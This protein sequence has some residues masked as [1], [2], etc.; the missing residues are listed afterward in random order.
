MDELIL[1]GAGRNCLNLCYIF[2]Q[3]DTQIS[4]IIVD[5]NSDKWNRRVG[6]YL[7]ESPDRIREFQ[8]MTLCITI[9]DIKA[10]KQIRIELQ[11]K[12]Q[13]NLEKEI[14]FNKLIIQV[15]EKSIKIKESMLRQKVVYSTKKKI[16]FESFNG[17]GLGGIESWIKGICKALIKAGV[18]DLYILSGKGNYSI[19]KVLENHILYTDIHY[20]E[21]YS[22]ESIMG[23]IEIIMHKL[24]CK[25]IVSM[26]NDV[27]LAAY[28]IKCYYPE[29]I[30]IIPVIH[31]GAE[32][33][34]DYY[35]DYNK[36]YGFYIVVSQDIRN[37]MVK[38]GIEPEKIFSITCP[39]ECNKILSRTY[40]DIALK[41]IQI[42][43]AG[44]MDGM[45][46]SQKRMDLLLK[47]VEVLIKKD[48]NFNMEFAGD[49]PARCRME[50]IVNINHWDNRVHFI[51]ILQNSKISDFWKEKDI[52]VNLADYEGRSIS[53]L[54][55]MGNGAV[56]IVTDTSGVKEDII[57]DINGYIIPLGDYNAAA[58]K[59]K[60]LAMNR[61]RLKGLGMAAH[62]VVYPK[63]LMEPHLDFWKKILKLY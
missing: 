35:L 36:G 51:G 28:L 49:G 52:C 48:V 59:V 6:N 7:I 3:L 21:Y 56:P 4:V 63:S 16:L 29:M 41:P 13:Y 45:E 50:K 19:P 1:Y 17:L 11:E 24:P 46:N 18:E 5:S 58:S 38:K 10:I 2:Q 22:V 31:V 39:F 32:R 25:I 55:A 34:Y 8:N 43:Y 12:Y 57:D 27:L 9:A 42:G 15:Y 30:E 23:L 20:G 54:E 62:D 60:Y 53:I 47:F 61:G 26:V 14:S 44:R 33:Y 37:G 40:T